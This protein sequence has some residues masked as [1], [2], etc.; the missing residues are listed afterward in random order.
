MAK[1]P[2]NFALDALE[3]AGYIIEDW[4]HSRS[5]VTVSHPFGN[6]DA[7]DISDMIDVV[8]DAYPM[9]EVSDSELIDG[10]VI[11]SLYERRG[12]MQVDPWTKRASGVPNSYY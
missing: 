6:I 9:L 12:G 2:F 10:V 3:D 5:E 4:N 8:E 1:P 11:L 7:R